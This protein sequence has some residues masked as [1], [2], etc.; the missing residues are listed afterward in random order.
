MWTRRYDR[1]GRLPQVIR[2]TKRFAGPTGLEED[3]GHGIGIALRV[4]AGDDALWFT[5]DHYFW[6]FAGRRWRLP[7][8]AAPGRMVVGHVDLGGGRFCFS[9]SL[10]HAWFGLL[11]EQVAMFRD[12]PAGKRARRARK[13]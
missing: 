8:W 1:I 5:S 10:R 2:S 13:G 7:G 12:P 9:L 3:L 11:V 6:R 4:E